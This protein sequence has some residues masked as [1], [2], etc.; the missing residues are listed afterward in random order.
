MVCSFMGLSVQEELLEYL[1]ILFLSHV[2]MPPQFDSVPDFHGCE[3]SVSQ[4][5]GFQVIWSNNSLWT[6]FKIRCQRCLPRNLFGWQ[7]GVTQVICV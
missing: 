4:H 1:P 5:A 2:F 3:S 7:E 6:F